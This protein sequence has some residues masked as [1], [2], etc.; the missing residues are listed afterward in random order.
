MTYSSHWEAFVHLAYMDESGTDG[1]CPVVIYGALIVPTGRFSPVE[2]LHSTAVQQILPVER[3]EEFKEFH[4]CDLY[5]GNEL[6]KGIEEDKRFNAIRVLLTTLRANNLYYVF[7]AVDRKK[8]KNSPFGS[9]KPLNT[10]LHMCL[11]GVEDWATSNHAH[12][13]SVGNVKQLDWNDTCLYILDDCDNKKQKDEFK[14]VYRTL[15]TKHPWVPPHENRLWHAHDN[16]FFAD[17]RDCV[18]IQIVDLCNYILKLHLEEAE[19]PQAFYK[20]FSERI[21]CAKPQPEWNQNGYLFREHVVSSGDED[22]AKS[23]A[24]Q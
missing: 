9:G 2:I 19:E 20:L 14:D 22:N 15:R 17:S 7:S 3:V 10:A 1:Y 23:Q 11:L 12:I 5:R 18:G 4:A 21:I 8:Y 16:M 24:A 6:F 13:H